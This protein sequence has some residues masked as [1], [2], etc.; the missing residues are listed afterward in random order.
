ME[1]GAE[2]EGGEGDDA[3]SVS[4]SEAGAPSATRLLRRHAVM[5]LLVLLVL[6][7]VLSVSAVM[8]A[9][10]P[11]VGNLVLDPGT[12]FHC[13]TPAF[14]CFFFLKNLQLTFFFGAA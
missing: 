8:A 2:D 14:S 12:S 4:S 1:E 10:T 5:A 13:A 11:G 6:Q 9:A 3:A 7:C